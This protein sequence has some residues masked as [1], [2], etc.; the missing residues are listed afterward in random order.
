MVLFLLLM[1]QS[2]LL[3]H[4]D[5]KVDQNFYL[6][7]KGLKYWKQ[8]V[9]Q[10]SQRLYESQETNENIIYYEASII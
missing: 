2:I 7:R 9:V 8:K 1:N 3:H 10:L 5:P 4:K 6:Q